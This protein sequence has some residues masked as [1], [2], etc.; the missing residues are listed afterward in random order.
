MRLCFLL[1][2]YSFFSKPSQ[3]F[4]LLY[5]RELNLLLPTYQVGTLTSELQ[6]NEGILCLGIGSVLLDF[7]QLV[8]I[9]A[10]RH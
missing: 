9:G 4:S 2:N 1:V 7:N 5:W 6:Y 3:P 8:E 10:S